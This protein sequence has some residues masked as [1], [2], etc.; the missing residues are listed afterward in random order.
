M[1][2]LVDHLYAKTSHVK[3]KDLTQSDFHNHIHEVK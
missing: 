2:T 3:K 1:E